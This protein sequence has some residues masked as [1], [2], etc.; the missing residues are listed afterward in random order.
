MR[1][2]GACSR[3]FFPIAQTCCIEGSAAARSRLR[4]RSRRQRSTRVSRATYGSDSPPGCHSLPRRL[5]SAAPAARFCFIAQ[6]CCIAGSAA[7]SRRP[8][9]HRRRFV[10]AQ[11]G[12]GCRGRQPL[13]P[14]SIIFY[15]SHNV[16]HPRTKP[17]NGRHYANA[18][19]SR[20]C[21]FP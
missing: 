8:T 16:A 14:V 5:P 9:V 4:A 1:R 19:R 10:S 20:V 3:R 6:M 21:S 13:Q 17:T 15:I 12:S 7:A 18:K 2:A 11:N